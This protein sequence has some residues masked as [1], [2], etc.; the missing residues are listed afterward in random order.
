MARRWWG[1][2]HNFL[3]LWPDQFEIYI[4]LQIPKEVIFDLGWNVLPEP[5]FVPENN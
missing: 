1:D 5:E 3:P 4:D 2:Q